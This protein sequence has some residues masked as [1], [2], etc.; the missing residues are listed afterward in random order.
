MWTSLG[1]PLAQKALFLLD[2]FVLFSINIKCIYGQNVKSYIY[3]G[4]VFQLFDAYSPY[5]EWSRSS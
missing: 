3:L 5:S 2:C 1:F 4:I